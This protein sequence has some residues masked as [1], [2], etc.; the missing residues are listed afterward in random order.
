MS[1]RRVEP[2]RQQLPSV[3]YFQFQLM[4]HISA[5]S[6]RLKGQTDHVQCKAY[7]ERP[8]L[9]Q[10]D[11]EQTVLVRDPILLPD[12]LIRLVHR[13]QLACDRLRSTLLGEKLRGSRYTHRGIRS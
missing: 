5:G 2:V 9:S 7:G 11:L 6:S 10:V 1:L 4:S 8:N 13:W 12:I 3:Q